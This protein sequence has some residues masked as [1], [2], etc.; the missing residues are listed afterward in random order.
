MGTPIPKIF[1]SLCAAIVLSSSP[2]ARSE[3]VENGMARDSAA[4]TLGIGG[5]AALAFDI[6]SIVYLAG[7]KGD[8]SGRI[9]TGIGSI[10]AGAGIIVPSALLLAVA[11]DETYIPPA[12][13]SEEEAMHSGRAIAGVTIGLGVASIA[14]GIAALATYGEPEGDGHVASDGPE[15]WL[16][17]H[18]LVVDEA[19]GVGLT[20]GG[21]F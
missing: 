13:G 19:S 16:L 3:Y 9:V 7:G 5:T 20:F 21:R 10:A 8:Q 4:M 14:V 11:F 2:D 15:L 6:A 1:G 12:G 18:P 17:P